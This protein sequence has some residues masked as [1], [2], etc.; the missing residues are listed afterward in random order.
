MRKNN[1]KELPRLLTA[2]QFAARIGKTA[3]WVRQTCEEGRIPA[4]QKV[5]GNWIIPEDALIRLRHTDIDLLPEMLDGKPY[6]EPVYKPNLG[7][8]KPWSSR[9]VR[10]PGLGRIMQER[11]LSRE[12]VH[13]LTGVHRDTLRRAQENR[14]VSPKTVV[15]LAKGLGVDYADLFKYK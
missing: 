12:R 6:G 10:I 4:A 14:P 5:G 1:Q 9:Q 15:K 8:P 3:R 2:R 7:N 11:G 13:W